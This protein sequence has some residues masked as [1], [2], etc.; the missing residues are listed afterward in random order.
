MCC[1]RLC[2]AR[3]SSSLNNVAATAA[4][5][6]TGC[7]MRTSAGCSPSLWIWPSPSTTAANMRL[8]HG[9]H[10][11]VVAN[12]ATCKHASQVDVAEQRFRRGGRA[13]CERSSC[14]EEAG[15]AHVADGRQGNVDEAAEENDGAAAQ[16]LAKR[17]LTD[18]CKQVA[19]SQLGDERVSTCARTTLPTCQAEAA[20]LVGV[21]V[22]AVHD[23]GAVH[24]EQGDE[25]QQL[26]RQGKPQEREGKGQ[27]TPAAQGNGESRLTSQE[28]CLGGAWGRSLE[29]AG[30]R[31]S[32]C[33]LW[34]EGDA[35]YQP[36]ARLVARLQVM[37]C[38]KVGLRPL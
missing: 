16:A 4:A 37:N 10:T 3:R 18:V 5:V 22:K 36:L 30:Q 8:I 17:R 14:L 12:T 11:L 19:L 1:A 20:L 34:E 25:Q 33:Q 21:L 13:A 29:A 32:P 31:S 24:A 6:S 7:T 28:A 26:E 27:P 23:G 9:R 38:E 35:Y 15:A 2:S